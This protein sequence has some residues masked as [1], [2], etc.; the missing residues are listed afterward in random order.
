LHLTCKVVGK[1]SDRFVIVA[2]RPIE[3]DAE[4]LADDATSITACLSNYLVMV[5]GH[6]V[7]ASCGC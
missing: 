4:E 7:I 5:A 2:I 1:W 6:E 3:D